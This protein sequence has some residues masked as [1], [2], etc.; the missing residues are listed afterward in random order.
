M[1]LKFAKTEFDSII[2]TR[3]HPTDAGIDLYAYG[4]YIIGPHSMKIIRTGIATILPSNSV[5]LFFPKGRNNWL[6]GAG[7]VDEGYRGELLVKITNISTDNVAI[8]HGDPVCQMV[9]VPCYTGP[10]EVV[11]LG[12]LTADKTDR[13]AT[14]G[15]VKQFALFPSEPE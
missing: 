13:G 9:I 8:K 6:I 3:K 14:G 11:D 10:S 1:S 4:D 5:G 12:A 15:I 7:V 2:P